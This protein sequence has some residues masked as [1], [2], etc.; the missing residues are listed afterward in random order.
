VKEDR[1]KWV[2]EPNVGLWDKYKAW[3]PANQ[4]I[5]LNSV[6]NTAA[7]IANP[8]FGALRRLTQW[9]PPN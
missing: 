8:E 4:N 1:W 2:S 9:Q 7:I 5:N 3:Q 6:T